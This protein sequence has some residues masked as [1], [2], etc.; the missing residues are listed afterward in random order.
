MLA[1]PDEEGAPMNPNDLQLQA[2]PTPLQVA[3][4]RLGK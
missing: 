2:L 3:P 4:V 1:N